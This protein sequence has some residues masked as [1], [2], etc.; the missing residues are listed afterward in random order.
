MEILPGVGQRDYY[1]SKINSI[2]QDILDNEN[3]IKLVYSKKSE[4]I[5]GW[6]QCLE[7]LGD[8]QTDKICSVIIDELI[9]MD[10]KRGIAHVYTVLDY[11]YKQHDKAEAGLVGAEARWDKEEPVPV[12]VLL[13]N[14]RSYV[15]LPNE[16]ISLNTAPPE[17]I[18]EN[19]E[20]LA[21]QIKELKRRQQEYI[22][23]MKNRHIAR[24]GQKESDIISTPQPYDIVHGHFYGEM[25]GLADDLQDASDTC[26]DIAKKIER[27]PPETE[28]QDQ[29]LA[30]GIKSWRPLFQWFNDHLRPYADLKFSLNYVDWFKAELLNRDYGKHAAAVKSKVETLSGQFR[31]M[32]REQIGDKQVII[33]DKAVQFK[34]LLDIANKAFE[35]FQK[36]MPDWHR[37]RV[38]PSVFTRKEM[39]GP[40][41]SESAFGAD[42]ST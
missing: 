19:E 38:A 1:V 29:K 15:N 13:N 39:V 25:V 21:R 7:E 27:Y 33:A 36:N 6:A 4:L 32:T 40:R 24:Q 20:F 17:D 11:K 5:R 37:T 23:A 2:K 12:D 22:D 30:D 10:C 28:A 18:Q 35:L 9:K 26:R 8:V 14:S 42:K 34:G 3:G 31:S 16:V 41:L